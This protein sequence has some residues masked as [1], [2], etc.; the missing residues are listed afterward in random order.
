MIS[1]KNRDPQIKTG[2]TA[3]DIEVKRIDLSP[4]AGGDS[5]AGGEGAGA[6]FKLVIWVFRDQLAN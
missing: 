4:F 3:R 2:K 6:S 5:P 1:T